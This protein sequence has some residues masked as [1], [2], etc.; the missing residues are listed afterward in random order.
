MPW[1][2]FLCVYPTWVS[3][4]FLDEWVYRF[5]QIWKIFGHY[6]FKKFSLSILSFWDFNYMHIILFDVVSWNFFSLYGLPC[7]AHKFPDLFFCT[8]WSSV[9]PTQW[10]SHLTNSVLRSK[11]PIWFFFTPS[12]SFSIMFTFFFK[13]LSHNY[14]SIL[15]SFHANSNIAVTLWLCFF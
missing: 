6:F 10:K 7:Y 1:C 11:L 12:N 2:G 13:S 4:I 9:K 15:K 8:R 5:H 3:L 14:E